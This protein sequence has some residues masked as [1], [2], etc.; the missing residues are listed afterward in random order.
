MPSVIINEVFDCGLVFKALGLF[1]WSL[2]Y[3]S[4]NLCELKLKLLIGSARGVLRPDLR[5]ALIEESN[6]WLTILPLLFFFC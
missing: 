1:L 6:D 5:L 3:F 4:C 2:L